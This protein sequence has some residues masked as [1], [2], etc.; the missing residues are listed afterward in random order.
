M[1]CPPPKIADIQ[2]KKGEKSASPEKKRNRK[3]MAMS[4]WTMRS[5]L[6]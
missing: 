1:N 5:E 4:Q 3:A 6:S 2:K